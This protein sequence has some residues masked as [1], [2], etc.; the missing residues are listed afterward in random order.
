M[1]VEALC[2]RG[3]HL[4]EDTSRAS[5]QAARDVFTLSIEK[6]P[7]AVCGHAG[8]SR[9]LA[10]AY[11]RRFEEDDAL[12][13]R[14]LEEARAAL[15]IDP[16]S[17]IGQTALAGALL[18]DLK[19]EDAAASGDA[20]LVLAPDSVPALQAA[21]V[22]RLAVGRTEEARQA[23]VKALSLRPDLPASYHTLGNIQ[24]MAGLRVDAVDSYRNALRLAPD[25]TPAALQVAAAYDQMGNFIAA[26]QILRDFLRDYPE[27]SAR[28]YL[29]TAYSSMGRNSWKTAL[30]ALDKASFKTRR[31]IS[32][33]TVLYLKGR[34]YEHLGRVEEARAAFR[35][36][37]EEWPD[38]TLS[39]ND[40]ERLISPS[41]EA[42]GRLHLEAHETDQAQVVM[43]EGIARTGASLDLYLRLA[44]LYEDY[45]MPDRA[46]ALLEQA[47]ARDMGPRNA[48]PLLDSYLLWARLA[49]KASDR[50]ALDRLTRRLQEQAPRLASLNDYVHDLGAMR[51]FSLAGHGEEALAILQRGVKAGYAQ[52]GWVASDP[53]LAAL[54][55]TEGF[56][57]LAGGR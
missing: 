57:R 48:G 8:L 22:T 26:G 53:D 10:A 39:F 30:A 9:A 17:A 7:D 33:G 23:I 32:D 49:S 1:P 24:L 15:K 50:A 44:R 18:I 11:L 35:K 5:N 4:L 13:D 31:G 46:T 12:I 47:V 3:E 38:A 56:R 21:A 52:V 20:A 41:Y 55:A 37:I 36:V 27:E 16:K 25:L 6:Y 29:Y 42:L 45:G 54:R 2:G 51:A 14:S 40:T 43:E 28:A 34:C 19:A